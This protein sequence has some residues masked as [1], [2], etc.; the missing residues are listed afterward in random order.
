MARVCVRKSDGKL[1]EYQPAAREGTLIRNAVEGG[2]SADDVEEKDL[3]DVEARSLVEKWIIA[4]SQK[5]D[6]K[7]KD[8]LTNKAE[9][10]RSKLGLSVEEWRTLLEA[11]K[12][13]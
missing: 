3:S 10:V 5:E 2:Y 4:P 1:V 9:N 6:Q 12:K 11:A 7:N 8:Q 13:L